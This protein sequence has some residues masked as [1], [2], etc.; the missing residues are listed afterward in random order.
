M[1]SRSIGVAIG[2]LLLA[3]CGL[4][5]EG[6][7]PV[8]VDDAG[9]QTLEPVDGSVG[10]SPRAPAPTAPTV[11]ARAASTDAPGEAKESGST[12]AGGGS[13]EGGS[14]DLPGGATLCCG[15]VACA[16]GDGMC[17]AAGVC[18]LCRAKC[19]DPKK[20]VCCAASSA[21][22]NCAATPDEC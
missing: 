6:L 9:S 11:D 16:D 7:G 17:A 1:T 10:S 8:P 13:L 22:V 3:A 21:T 15:S 20:P 18:A 5:V 14:C 12:S 4:G 19:I 2:A